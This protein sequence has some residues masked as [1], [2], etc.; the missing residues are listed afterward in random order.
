MAVDD[1]SFG[2]REHEQGSGMFG[3]LDTKQYFEVSRIFTL[4]THSA[5]LARF[6]AIGSSF[7]FPM[8]L[9]CQVLLDYHVEGD[10]TVM[11]VVLIL[12]IHVTSRVRSFKF[13][14]PVLV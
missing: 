4:V 7:K 10:C 13:D 1:D 11:P 2:L 8:V 12:I 5:W 6:R 3:L 14:I 9:W